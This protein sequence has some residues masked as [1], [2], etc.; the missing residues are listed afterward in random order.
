MRA[1]YTQLYLHCVWATWDRLPL[2][3]PTV[4]PHVYACIATK[5]EEHSCETLAVGGIEDHIHLLVRFPPTL[6]IAR[7]MK[8]VKG[9]SS[10]LMTHVLTPDVFFKWQGGY[11]AFTVTKFGVDKARAYVEKQKEHHSANRLFSE[12]ERYEFDDK[13][14]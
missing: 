4:E 7:I 12:W 8:E 6:E 3:T 14:A 11:G 5:C 2:I 9:A 10:H 13:D 1:P